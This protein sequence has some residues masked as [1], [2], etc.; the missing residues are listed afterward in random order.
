MA[1]NDKSPRKEVDWELIE[2]DYRAGLLSVREIAASQGITHAAINKRAKRDGWERDLKAKIQAKAD[3]LVSKREVSKEV[4][5][6]RVETDRVIVEANAV[7]IADVRMAHRTDIARNRALAIEMLRELESQTWNQDQFEELAELVIGP[8]IYGDDPA[9]KAAERRRQKLLDAF[10]RTMSLPGRVDSMKK[11]A[12]TLRVL[13]S[14]ER[15]AY[16][17]KTETETP[18]NPLADF[19]HQLSGKTLR[20]VAAPEDD[21]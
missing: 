9:D 15:E 14:M 16:G 7:R 12:E 1:E 8:P 3:A 18:A 17:I 11:L 6:E 20:P 19:M 10:D 13:V 2:R 5:K 4:S 21:E